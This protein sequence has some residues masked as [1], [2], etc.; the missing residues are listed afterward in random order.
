MAPPARPLSSH[1]IPLALQVPYCSG[2]LHLG[3]QG[4]TNADGVRFAGHHIVGG[5]L[6]TAAA[7]APV[8]ASAASTTGSRNGNSSCLFVF[9]H[10]S[11][12]KGATNDT[13]IVCCPAAAAPKLFSRRSYSLHL[14]GCPESRM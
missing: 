2:D 13:T 6:G 1:P 7:F 12:P 11:G 10:S 14:A 8:A 5:I 4:E 9:L 3:T